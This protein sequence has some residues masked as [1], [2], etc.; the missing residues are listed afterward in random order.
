MSG[1][2][3]SVVVRAGTHLRAVPRLLLGYS[4]LLVAWWGAEQALEGA[5]AVSGALPA[6]AALSAA[7]S[8]LRRGPVML[9]AVGVRHPAALKHVMFPPGADPGTHI[10]YY[11]QR[12]LGY[13]YKLK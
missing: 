1:L 10:A 8:A 13:C 5:G 6:A 4:R 3:V 2:Y 11:N 9:Q 12:L 7:N